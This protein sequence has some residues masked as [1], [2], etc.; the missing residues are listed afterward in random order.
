MNNANNSSKFVSATIGGLLLVLFLSGVFMVVEKDAD[1][2]EQNKK[3]FGTAYLIFAALLGMFYI[4]NNLSRNN[5]G[6]PR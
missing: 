3:W 6:Y 2:K 4:Y 5:S 1:P